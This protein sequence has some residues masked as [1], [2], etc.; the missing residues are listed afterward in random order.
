MK[1]YNIIRL[2]RPHQWVKNLFIFVPLFFSGQMLQA[3]SLCYSVIAFVAFSF[4]ASSIYCLN[5][6]LDVESDRKHETKC[7]RPIASGSI[8]I[9][10]AYGI[11]AALMLGSLCV[12][13]CLP[14]RQCTALV[15]IAAYCLLNVAY[16]LWL[17][18]IAIIDVVII[19][20]GFVMRIVLG[21]AVTGI[22]LTHWIVI[23]TFLLA[24]FLA[25]AKRRDDVLR[26]EET[27]VA[28]RSNIVHYNLAY[29]NQ[30]L[31]ILATTTLV[32]Y[33]M[34]TISPEV[35]ERFHSQYVYTTSVF[36]LLGLLRYLQLTTVESKSGSPTKVMLTDIFMQCCVLGWILAFACLIYAV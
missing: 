16:C 2:I 21:G 33:I 12:A 18:H 25:I 7:K 27:G 6:I 1:F 11:M 10:L 29:I 5:D 3:T 20:L 17:K 15:I 35:E 19:S 4:A 23:M 31:T 30:V 9:G 26:Y 14:D 8:G 24:L 13:L 34:Y 32:A 28:V 22:A 36:V